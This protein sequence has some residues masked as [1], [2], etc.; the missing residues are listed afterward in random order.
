MGVGVGMGKRMEN[1]M[2]KSRSCD[3]GE[4]RL[5]ASENYDTF[6]KSFEP[7]LRCECIHYELYQ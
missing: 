6:E 5:E 3:R 4:M 2:G 7:S 1:E